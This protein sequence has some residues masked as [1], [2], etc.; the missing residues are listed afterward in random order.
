MCFPW[1]FSSFP[2]RARAEGSLSCTR[3]ARTLRGVGCSDLEV[4]GFEGLDGDV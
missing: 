1:C 2:W 4:D 3:F